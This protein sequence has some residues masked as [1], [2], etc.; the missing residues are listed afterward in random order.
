MNEIKCPKC[1]EVFSVDESGY[2]AIAAQIRDA[3]FQKELK[4]REQMLQVEKENELKLVQMNAKNELEKN[5]SIS[6]QEIEKLKTLVDA[7]NS[8]MI[9]SLKDEQAKNNSELYEKN[10]RITMLQEELNRVKHTLNNDKEN[11]VKLVT[12]NAKVE[13]EEKLSESKQEIERFKAMVKAKDSDNIIAIKDEQVKN[14]NDLNLK[15]NQIT[16]LQEELNRVKQTMINDKENEVKLVSANAKVELEEKLSLYKQEIE[17]LKATI[18]SKESDKI[19]A[20]KNEEVKKKEELFEKDKHISQLENE[21]TTS[22]TT[23]QLKMKSIQDDFE[24]KIK[25]KEETID[26]YKDLKTKL[27][28]KMLGESLEQHCEIEFNR[29]RSIGFQNAYFEKD[30]D[31]RSGSKGDYIFKEATSSGIE[32]I[33]IMFEMKNEMD[34]TATKKKNEDF[35]KE[36]DKDRNEKNCEYAVLV[37]L[38]ESDNELYNTGIVDMSYKYPK[39]YIIRPQFFISMITVLRNAALNSIQYREQLAE[40]KNQNIDISN[41][42]EDMMD[43]KDKFNKNYDLASRKFQTAI[44]EIDKTID[45][46]NKTKDALLS[47]E[48]NLRLASNKAQDLSIKKLVKNNPT[49]AQKFS[50]IKE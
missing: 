44:V 46:L 23:A 7:K 8:E 17:K 40:Y 43:F 26:Y 10:N 50:G 6:K 20:L 5:L 28:T 12:A 9:I 14:S 24:A 39:M 13:L 31:A 32:F 1:G 36:L 30:N 42:E 33:S 15:N 16:M 34:T 3:E 25:A 4:Q 2:I 45:H 11:E 18:V 27:S 35:L 41:F 37:S 22:N 29:L 47:S 48:N 49:M 38:L 19:I 21:V